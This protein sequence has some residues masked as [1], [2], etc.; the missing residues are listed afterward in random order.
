MQCTL[1]VTVL[2]L[3]TQTMNCSIPQILCCLAT[4]ISLHIGIQCRLSLC[5]SLCPH[6]LQICSKDKK[7]AKC[8]VHHLNCWQDSNDEIHRYEINLNIHE[9]HFVWTILWIS[10]IYGLE[11]F[12]D[13]WFNCHHRASLYGTALAVFKFFY[14]IKI[15]LYCIFM[16]S[17]GNS[18]G[19]VFV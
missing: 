15:L 18:T 3:H 1:I 16:D 10:F 5:G 7:D 13:C 6:L 19:V 8:W 12:I 2:I 4:F 17:I 14:F 9:K 11:F